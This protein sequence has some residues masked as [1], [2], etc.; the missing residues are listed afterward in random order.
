MPRTLI[1][2]VLGLICVAF[3]APQALQ[4][5]E[6]QTLGGVAESHNNHKIEDDGLVVRCRACGAP[7]AKKKDYIDFHDTINTVGSRYEAVLGDDTELFTFAN[8][9]RTE[10]ELAGFKEVSAIEGDTYTK[11]SSFFDNYSWQDLRCNH[12]KKHVGWTF[13]HEDYKQCLRKQVV[14]FFSAA[15]NEN[16]PA[17]TIALNAKT[18]LVRSE[19]SGQCLSATSDWWTYEI[20]YETEVRQY[21]KDPGGSR[22]SEWSMGVYKTF[23]EENDDASAGTDVV[24]YYA[25]G[26]HCDENGKLRSTSVVYKC[27]ESR[28]KQIE[29]ES[30]DE[31]ELCSYLITVCIPRLCEYEQES[32]QNPDGNLQLSGSCKDQFDATHA[33]ETVLPKFAALRWSSVISEDSSELDWTRKMQF[34]T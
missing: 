10:V 1:R 24:Q 12:C 18:D 5:Q 33:D 15:I 32:M 8:P 30:V 13:Y 21:H 25:G 7:V 4:S 16:P 22:V 28:P 11:K 34:A 31:P 9:S 20:C 27:C 26:Q 14:D 2:F 3:L 29:V 6:L 23:T 17:A 19:L